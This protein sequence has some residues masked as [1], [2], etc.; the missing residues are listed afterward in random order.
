MAFYLAGARDVAIC[1][2]PAPSVFCITSAKTLPVKGSSITPNLN[3]TNQDTRT[4]TILKLKTK[5]KTKIEL[6]IFSI[7]LAK[8]PGQ[9]VGRSL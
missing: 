7:A 8:R 6:S 1:V 5:T 2:R 9:G 3:L 4:K